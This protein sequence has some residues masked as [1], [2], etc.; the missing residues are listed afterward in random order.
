M[1]NEDKEFISSIVNLGLER[2]STLKD[3][4]LSDFKYNPHN[5][6]KAIVYLKDF[7]KDKELSERVK[8]QISK[9]YKEH[10]KTNPPKAKY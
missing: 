7:I 10:R 5:M 6:Y 1:L 3:N 2:I 8:D 9:Y 4:E